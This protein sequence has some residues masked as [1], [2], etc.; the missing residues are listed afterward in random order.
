MITST[1]YT[2]LTDVIPM[3]A[4]FSAG[5]ASPSQVRRSLGEGTDKTDGSRPVLRPNMIEV[6]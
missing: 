5:R 2:T 4:C 6:A 1:I 3:G